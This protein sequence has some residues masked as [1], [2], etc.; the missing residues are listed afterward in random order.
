MDVC[1]SPRGCRSALLGHPLPPAFQGPIDDWTGPKKP[2]SN[3]DWLEVPLEAP[4]PV[5]DG[6]RTHR[7]LDPGRDALVD[8]RTEGIPVGPEHRQSCSPST[9]G[10]VQHG[11]SLASWPEPKRASFVISHAP[12]PP[13]EVSG[14][15]T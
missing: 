3:S 14:S 5:M 12:I 1:Q 9:A 15:V 7:E 8:R 11:S 10:R 13:V 6:N 4:V 2:A